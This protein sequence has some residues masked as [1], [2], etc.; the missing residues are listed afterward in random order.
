M[1]ERQDPTNGILP[2]LISDGWLLS[3]YPW[4]AVTECLTQ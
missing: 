2:Q 4:N 1:N 3:A